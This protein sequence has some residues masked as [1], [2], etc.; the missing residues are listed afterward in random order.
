M[1]RNFARALALVLKHEGGWPDHPADYG[2]L[3]DPT[4]DAR[5]P[6][7]PI[8]TPSARPFIPTWNRYGAVARH[9]RWRLV[10]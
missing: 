6:A 8:E 7:S 4:A 10:S 1:D 3:L 9:S 5:Q 2:R